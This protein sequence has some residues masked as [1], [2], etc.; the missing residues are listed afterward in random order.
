[1]SYYII[2]EIPVFLTTNKLIILRD[3]ALKDKDSIFRVKSCIS[4]FPENEEAHKLMFRYLK[5]EYEKTKKNL[6]SFGLNL[7]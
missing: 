6:S 3:C 1:M 4:G 5:Q 2:N 7:I